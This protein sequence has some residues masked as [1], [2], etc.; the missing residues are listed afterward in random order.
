MSSRNLLPI[1]NLHSSHHDVVRNALANIL[2]SQVAQ[3]TYG[4]ILDGLPLASA[5]MDVYDGEMVCVGHPLVDEHVALSST[6]LSKINELRASVPID[7]FQVD[8]STVL[9]FQAAR[10]GSQTF[11]ARLVELVAR[12]I[13]AIAVWIYTNHSPLRP[14]DDR[15]MAWRPEKGDLD[16]AYRKGYPPTLFVHPWYTAYDQYPDGVADGVGYWAE[17]R[18]FGGVVLFDR[19]GPDAPDTIYE[20]SP[21]SK[22]VHLPKQLDAVYFHTNADNVTYRIYRLRTDQRQRLL[23]F[24]LSP[25]DA[26]ASSTSCPLP[27]RGDDDNRV[28]IDPEEPMH[29]TGIYRDLWERKPLDDGDDDC[30]SRDVVDTFNFLSEEDYQAAMRRYMHMKDKR[31]EAYYRQ[32]PELD[33]RRKPI[34]RNTV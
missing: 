16:W 10:P 2:S 7:T 12:V 29:E 1:G 30:R 20:D 31:D 23:H 32:H 24:L 28:R 3:T 21:V 26:T 6:V 14:K 25:A 17:D 11:Q 22:A 15:L 18:I 9:D 8:A 19:R 13:H 4:Q 34:N 5:A 33:P 27:I